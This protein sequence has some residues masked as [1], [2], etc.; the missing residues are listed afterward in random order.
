[1]REIVDGCLAE[2]DVPA[3]SLHDRS[4]QAQILES[5]MAQGDSG[6]SGGLHGKGLCW[7]CVIFIII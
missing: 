1:V 6:S 7:S 5:V 3:L 4:Q 2:R